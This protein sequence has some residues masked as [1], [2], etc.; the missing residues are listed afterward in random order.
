MSAWL[1]KVLM[2]VLKYLWP[3][4]LDEFKDWAASEVEARKVKRARAKA[5]EAAKVK[6]DAVVAKPDVTPGEK[7]DAYQDLINS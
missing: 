3:L 7:A 4:I 5:T 6:Y 1:S 2:S